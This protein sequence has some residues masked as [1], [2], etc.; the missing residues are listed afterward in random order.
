MPKTDSAQEVLLRLAEKGLVCADSFVPVRQWQNREKIKKAAARQR[1]GA[2]VMAL[3]AGRWDIVRPRKEKTREE[4]LELFFRQTP[5][6]C[7]ETFRKAVSDCGQNFTWPEA[8][9]SL[10]IWEYTGRV[11]RGYFASGL[12]GA[13][14]IRKEEFEGVTAALQTAQNSILWMNATDPALSLIHI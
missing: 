11:R 12:S 5:I 7:R 2:R 8:L 3:S 1:V 13:Q 14:F 6:L 4:W 10:R 9:E